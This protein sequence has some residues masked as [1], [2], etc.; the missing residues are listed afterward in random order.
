ME[1]FYVQKNATVSVIFRAKKL[2]SHWLALKP[3][4][5]HLTLPSSKMT[6]KVRIPKEKVFQSIRVC[7]NN[8]QTASTS[9]LPL[10]S[11]PERPAIGER[12]KV[13]L[14]LIFNYFSCLS[15]L[16]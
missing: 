11:F 3:A 16:N 15:V 5:R 10:I 6:A 14:Q 4:T 1:L 13:I 8:F 12:C 2:L 9:R 7:V